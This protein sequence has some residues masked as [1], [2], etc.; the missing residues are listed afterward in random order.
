MANTQK[1]ETNTA[2]TKDELA[3]RQYQQQM[4]QA[5]AAPA[6]ETKPTATTQQ[7]VTTMPTSV[8]QVSAPLATQTQAN[9][10]TQPYTPSE[11]VLKAQQMLND[12]L[13]NKPG[14]YQ[15]TWQNTL[16]DLYNKIQNRE[17]FEFDL[18]GDAL[19]QQYKDQYIN[20]GRLA[21]M[22]TMGQAAALTGG[23]G[24]SYAQSV[25]QQTYQGYLNQLNDKIPELY[26][27]ALDQYNREGDDLYQQY[28]LV[29]S[30]DQQDYA[31]YQDAYNNWMNDRNFYND[32]YLNERNFDYGQWGD[33]RNFN[34]QLGRDQVADAQWQ[35]SFDYNAERDRIADQQWQSEFDESNR[36]WQ[37]AFDESNRQWQAEY[38]E[39]MRQYNQN[40]AYQQERDTVADNQW[41]QQF[42]EARRQ[43]EQEYAY[44]Q[45]RDAV[46]DQQ[47]QTA[48]DYDKSRD[49]T[50]DAQWQAE[51]D[52]AKRQFDLQY[53]LSASKASGG[54]GGSGGGGNPTGDTTKYYKNASGTS[55]KESDIDSACASF[56][57]SNSSATLD[58]T[59]V[60]N[61]LK[62]K[63][64]TGDAATYAK[65]V[66]QSYGMTVSRGSSGTSGGG[67]KKT[68]MTR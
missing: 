25:G 42:E 55:F 13:A 64:Y 14:E 48:F 62:S 31:R 38:D 60:E 61:F 18:N 65:A 32:S 51:F 57:K 21:M 3:E 28:S 2:L 5:N 36:Q 41:N 8:K 44:Q 56:Y 23:Y 49:T 50:A 63:G 47:W 9:D 29:N 34:Y 53:G 20:G 6:I 22:D 12:Q 58:S 39:A 1:K 37:S 67:T 54:S 66:L 4:E 19:Y 35:Q 24:N 40:F 10:Y 33:Q 26:Q 16:D 46:S 15:S 59:T 11:S 52:E 68:M 7:K 27:L 30:R 45:S 43:Y 17:K